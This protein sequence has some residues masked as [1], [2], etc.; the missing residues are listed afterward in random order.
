MRRVL[1]GVMEV[2]RMAVW[3]LSHVNHNLQFYSDIHRI[4]FPYPL[5]RST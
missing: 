1:L 2:E 5:A 4:A 3:I